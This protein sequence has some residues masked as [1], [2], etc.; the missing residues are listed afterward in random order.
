MKEGRREVYFYLITVNLGIH[1]KNGERRPSDGIFLSTLQTSHV[2]FIKMRT[3]WHVG[4]WKFPSGYFITLFSRNSWKLSGYQR[5]S[6][7]E[8]FSDDLVSADTSLWLEH[9][10]VLGDGQEH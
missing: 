5:F 6:R 4:L 3:S 2:H 8:L 10:L 9:L 7:T 1:R